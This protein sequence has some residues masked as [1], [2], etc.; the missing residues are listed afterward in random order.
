MLRSDAG[1]KRDCNKKTAGGLETP[2]AHDD[3]VVLPRERNRKCHREDA[4][5]DGV[6]RRR[7]TPSALLNKIA[8]QN[9]W[10]KLTRTQGAKISTPRPTLPPTR[11]PTPANTT[12]A[13]IPT[14]PTIVMQTLANQWRS[15]AARGAARNHRLRQNRADETGDELVGRVAN[16]DDSQA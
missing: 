15:P 8:F 5:P 11:R 12:L 10:S 9:S 3:V 7:G 2:G 1:V 14:A 4:E 6:G 16:H 13:T